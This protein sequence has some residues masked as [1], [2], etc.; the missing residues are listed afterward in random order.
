MSPV[1]FTFELS[2]RLL[3]L[4]VVVLVVVLFTV[5]PLLTLLVLVLELSVFVT[6][7]DFD[8][9]VLS[10]GSSFPGFVGSGVSLGSVPGSI[11]PG[12][13]GSVGVDG[14]EGSDGSTGSVEPF[15]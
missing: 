5:S 2:T 4:S 12:F 6:L 10:S 7:S 1:L 14:S 13:S 3:E 9:S 11:S 8:G 15:I